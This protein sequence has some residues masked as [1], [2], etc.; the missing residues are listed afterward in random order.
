M[1][2]TAQAS[3]LAP[4]AEPVPVNKPAPAPVVPTDFFVV[5]GDLVSLDGTADGADPGYAAFRRVTEGMDVIRQ[6]LDLPRDPNAG[7][8][9]MKGQMLA[10]PVRILTVRRAPPTVDPA[11]TP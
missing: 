4:V 3:E 2:A 5:I 8:A 9:V 11:A 10:Q 6:M 1:F 7:D